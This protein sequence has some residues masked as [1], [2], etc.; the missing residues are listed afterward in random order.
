MLG[1][2]KDLPAVRDMLSQA[3]GILGYDLL[4]AR[5][6]PSDT[7]LTAASLVTAC[8]NLTVP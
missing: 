1:A 7:A 2:S 5:P 3:R 8:I 6:A 4:Q